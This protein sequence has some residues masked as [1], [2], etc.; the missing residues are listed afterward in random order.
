MADPEDIIEENL[1]GP[2]KVIVDGQVV[3]NYD[4]DEQVKAAKYLDQKKAASNGSR[5]GI[6]RFKIRPGGSL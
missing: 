5:L 4:I 3:E 6:Q 1:Q 2:K